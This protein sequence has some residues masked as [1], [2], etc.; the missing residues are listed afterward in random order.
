[1]RQLEFSLFDFVLHQTFSADA[2]NVMD[3]Q[4]ILDHVRSKTA[5]MPVPKFNR[6]QNT[7][8]HIFGGGYAA[9]Y[10][11]YLWSEVLAADVFDQFRKSHQVF[12]KEIAK[13]FV[14][15]ILAK[16]GSEEFMDLFVAFRGRPPKIDALL[17]EYNLL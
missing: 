11:S 9:G 2:S 13:K 7:F 6:F 8:S 3:I 4:E 5:I 10:Y 17:K 1:M 14:E 12:N 16:G 15:T